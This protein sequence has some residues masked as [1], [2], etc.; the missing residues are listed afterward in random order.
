MIPTIAVTYQ[1]AIVLVTSSDY[2]QSE[3]TFAEVSC[4]MLCFGRLKI[5][6]I[7]YQQCQPKN[8]KFIQMVP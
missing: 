4:Y 1:A 8:P 5:I 6:Y 2:H 3:T 7:M